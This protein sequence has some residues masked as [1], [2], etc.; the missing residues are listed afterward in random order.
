[1]QARAAVSDL[2]TGH[3]RRPVIE[4][5]GRC[6]TTGAL[7]DVLVDL[8]VLVGAGAEALHRGDYHA[9]IE[10]LNALPGEAHAVESAGRKI[11]HEHVAVLHQSLQHLLAALA[12]RVERHRTLVVIQHGEIEAVDVRDIAQP[13]ARNFTAARLFD[14][15]HVGAEPSE[16]LRAGGTRLHVREI[17]NSNSVQCLTH[18]KLRSRSLVHRLILGA[19]R[20]F[21]RIDP[22][23]DHRRTACL[24][25]GLTRALQGRR[26]LRGVA[27]LFAVAAE[28]FGELAERNV[29]EQIAHAA[30][31]LAVF[32]QLAVADLVHRGI[33]AD[34]R[35]IGH[36]EAVGRL[37]VEGR[38]AEG[39]VAVVAQDF[40]GRVRE[41]RRDRKSGAH[42]ERA[43]SARIHPLAR[44]PRAPSLRRDGDYI[45]AVAD[46]YG[47]VAQEF[48][49]L[50]GDTVG[51]DRHAVR[52]E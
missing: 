32:R 35:E 29:A 52:L 51:M 28:H 18:A 49:E 1:M 16:Q 37:H 17:Q 19:R 36:A 40:L 50:P 33:V 43:E 24:L 30:P 2:R 3:E 27:H 46:V 5:S 41:P 21:A 6:G 7:G 45:A 38:H 10:C 47:V 14:F 31:L 44:A 9:R 34:D 4:T 42:A 23:I 25:Y 15:D 13:L 39:A 22:D 11:L 12:F 8:A 26:Y 20:V 48:V